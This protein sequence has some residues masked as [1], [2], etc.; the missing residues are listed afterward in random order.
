MST[1]AK[2]ILIIA[3]VLAFLAL[4]VLIVVSTLKS[5]PPPV[6]VPPS[7]ELLESRLVGRKDGQRQWEI[8]SRSV[9][10]TGDVVTLRDMDEIVLFQDEEPYLSIWAEQAV[11]ERKTDILKLEG[12]VVV[13]GEDEFRLE[14]D[15]L[16]WNGIDENLAS[17]G[18]VFMRWD[19]LDIRA[20]QM[21]LDAANNLLYLK[22]GV[23]I[24]DGT[25][26]WSLQEVVYDISAETMDFY[27]ELVLEGEVGA[28]E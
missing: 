4:T 7:V 23:Q 28:G 1:K 17:P 15:L 6:A 24:Q 2:R 26:N 25:L 13:E 20:A 21:V 5:P 12:H 9:L 14:S 16:V 10:Q 27:G 11:W 18:A 22:E 3:I 8:L 19:G